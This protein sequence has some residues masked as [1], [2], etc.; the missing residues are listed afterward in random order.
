MPVFK[1]LIC[2]A[3]VLVSSLTLAAQSKRAILV[4]IN[5]YNPDPSLRARLQQTP[6]AAAARPKIDGDATYWRFDNLD[7]AL[8]DL[9]LMK[10]VL[11]DLGI[12]DFV[13]LRDQE[14]TAA[15]IL[16]A[17]QKNLVDDAKPGD[18]RIFYYS[19]HGNHLRNLASHE[20]G[21]EDQT[22][23][24]ADNWRD[25][26]DVRDKEIS[27]I[28]WRAARKGVRVTFIADSCHSG[29][30]SRGAWNASRKARSSSGRRGGTGANAPREP[31]ANDP[32][33]LDPATKQPID[34]EKAGV[35]TLA[36]AQ[37]TEEAREVDTEDG[38][39][40]AFTW[41]LAHALKYPGEPMNQVLQRISAQLHAS[42]VAQQPV[43]GGLGR[44]AQ[45]LFGQAADASAGLR[46]LVESVNGKD[47]RLRGGKE[48]EL[49]PDCVLKSVANPPVRLKITAAD[50][51]GSSTA[52]VVGDGAV[53]AG[54]LFSVE[55]WV[56]PSKASL[57]VFL[58]PAAPPDTIGKV[59]AEAVKLKADNSVDWVADPTAGTPTH[60]MSWSGASWILETNPAQPKP[61]DLGAAPA[62]D[63]VRKLLP[64]H[65]R[66]LLIVPPTPALVAALH[67][68]A[69]V[70]IAKQRADAQYW[71]SGRLSGGSV[72]YAW[73]LADATQEG[74]R[75][76]GDR[77][78]L[79]ARSDWFAGGASETE[80]QAAAGSL[81]EKSRLL[82]RIRGWL[83]LESPPSQGS[84]P[85]HLVLRNSDTGE[86]HTA[87][88]VRDGEKYQLYL[89]ADEAA[90][91][92]TKDLAQRWVYIF[93]VDS[94]GQS[95]LIYPAIE[96]GNEG[97]L[98][99]YAQFGDHPKFEPL[100]ALT[101]A[102]KFAFSVEA[103]F[104]VDSY[105]LLTSQEPINPAVFSAEGV[106]TRAGTR[107]AAVADPLSELLSDVNTGSRGVRK[108]ETP[109][110]WS[111]EVQS[112]R[113]APK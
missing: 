77:L 2:L 35:L 104:G 43:M 5:N 85:Y 107:S 72:E 75:Q 101:D 52:Q 26:P 10:S 71:L 45:D 79:P 30:L 50:A 34:P 64:E 46:I 113:S 40:G 39:H 3:A 8:N 109:A 112:I 91:K 37:A 98:Q 87:G 59:V 93:I 33:D 81:S 27:R 42:G 63:A 4:G 29:S 6:I 20:Q 74:A 108:A 31:V 49:Y 60:I 69:G 24:P 96:H 17:L 103:P 92:N 19:G 15:A 22:I 12:N 38:P 110:T 78:P 18:I 7:G 9:T 23:V 47:V 88:D 90:L 55:R 99:P 25:V 54:D 73:L 61:A 53:K 1:Y 67:P 86:F 68:A 84:F 76:L 82:A 95:Q 94:F 58:P 62:A 106:R 48:L 13:I 21:E 65:A 83:T 56:T 97:N 11:G 89:K 28:L 36:A 14:A 51:L 80:A 44:G 41:A 32:A 100:I 16:D 66:F 105:F 102:D 57:R 70:E 111:I